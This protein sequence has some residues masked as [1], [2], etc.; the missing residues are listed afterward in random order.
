[1]IT[2]KKK[3]PTRKQQMKKYDTKWS[4]LVKVR[5]WNKCEIPWCTRWNLNSH[6]IFTRMNYTT[7]FDLDNW[8]C[9]CSRHHTLNPRFS[10]HKT[11]TEFTEWI[12]EYRWEKRYD[13]LR[14]KS[15]QT[16]DR[17]YDKVKIYLELKEKELCVESTTDQKIE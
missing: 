9:L 2:K 11:P 17:N 6:H 10:A 8:I 13:T 16:R 3:K 14:L 15:N 12:K 4:Y 7:R 5:A 1:M